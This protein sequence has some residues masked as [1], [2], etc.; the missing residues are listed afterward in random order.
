MREAVPITLGRPNQINRSWSSMEG[1]N[2]SV[3]WRGTWL[4]KS[5]NY[6]RLPKIVLET[7]NP[8]TRPIMNIFH[9]TLHIVLIIPIF[10]HKLISINPQIFN[11]IV[12]TTQLKR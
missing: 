8:F 5:I 2:L 10:T 1:D 6:Q 4:T 12:K 11:Q 3:R 9:L 7:D